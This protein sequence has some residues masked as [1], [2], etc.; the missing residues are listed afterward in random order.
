MTAV[1][2]T[3]TPTGGDEGS[4]SYAE[5]DP[6]S[7]EEY[8]ARILS[9]SQRTAELMA[10]FKDYVSHDFDDDDD[11]D[12]N[13]D[14]L[15]TSLAVNGTHDDEDVENG[16]GD[17]DAAAVPRGGQGVKGMM[18]RTENNITPQCTIAC[19]ILLRSRFFSFSSFMILM[20]LYFE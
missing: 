16:D 13:D 17:N 18:V 3:T 4:G 14:G 5:D 7:Q 19:L 20:T 6:N 11:D 9:L 10:N 8:R 1:T 15:I 2:T 12:E